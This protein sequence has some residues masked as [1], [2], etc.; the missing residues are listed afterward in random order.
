VVRSRI[1]DNL[2]KNLDCTSIPDNENCE[3]VVKEKLVVDNEGCREIEKNI[4]KQNKCEEWYEQRKCRLI[5]SLFSCVKKRR[6][7]T[8]NKITKPSKTRNA[9]CQWGI[10]LKFRP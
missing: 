3:I 10:N 7:S 8:I 6:K 9:N 4:R 2:N 5:S 1:L